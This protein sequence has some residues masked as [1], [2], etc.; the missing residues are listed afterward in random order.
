MSDDP[1]QMILDAI[2]N[3]Q[4]AERN[5]G[6]DGAVV[7]KSTRDALHARLLAEYRAL[8]RCR[9]NP[10]PPYEPPPLFPVVFKGHYD[11]RADYD[12]MHG[13]QDF[14]MVMNFSPNRKQ[15]WMSGAAFNLQ[16]I[17]AVQRGNAAGAFDPQ[18]G[19]LSIPITFDLHHI[20]NAGD[21]DATLDFPNPG[22]TTKQAGAAG[23]Y[24]PTGSPLNR[25]TTSL[26]LAGATSVTDNFF[27][28]LAGGVHV[29]IVA[30]G[31]LSPLP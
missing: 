12:G 29:E 23:P 5:L 2:D 7:L 13:E 14:N 3:I 30:Q 22:L 6:A 9:A 4:E 15:L 11:A 20:P 31:S 19:D 26:A 18:T 8:Q 16:G 28:D 10:P 17:V 25:A 1:C 21:G 24:H 27:V